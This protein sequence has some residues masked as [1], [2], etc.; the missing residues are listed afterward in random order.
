MISVILYGRN[1]AHGYNL[2]RRAALSLNCIAEV[3]TDPDDEIVFVDYNTPDELP[4][5]IEAI[6]DTLTERCLRL[7]RVVRV[8]A[9]IHEQGFAD[10]TPL[11]VVEP[12]ARNVAA[13]R[14]NPANRWLLSTNTD[15]IFVPLADRSLSE[16]CSDLSDGF[17]GLPR[18]E[19][20]EWLWERLP[21]N[22]PR[23]ALAEVQRLGP[24]LRL[25]E[26]T[27]SH[28]WIRFDAPGDFQLIL[29]DDFVAIHGFDENMRRGYHVDSNV[30]RRLLMH[31]GSIE[32]I[33][34]YLAGYHCNHNRTRTVYHGS[35]VENDI[36]TFFFAIDEPALHAQRS[37]WGL[38]EVSLEEAPIGQLVSTHS[39][40]MLTNVMSS[41]PR[42]PSNAS[43]APVSLAYD[44]GHVLPFIADTLIVSPPHMAVG[45]LGSNVSLERML[46]AFVESHGGDRPLQAAQFHDLPTVDALGRTADILVIDLGIDV[47]QVEAP[48]HRAGR[49]EID[50]FPAAFE[51]VFAALD[52]LIELERER[53]ERGEHPR[54]IVLVN[55]SADYWDTYVLAQF[56]C[57]YTTTHSRVRRAT[58]KR[59]PDD[60]VGPRTARARARQLALWSARRELD[61][62]DVTLRLGESVELAALDDYSG[63]GEG[64]SYPQELGIWAQGPRSSLRMAV[65]GI[66]GSNATEYV[67]TLLIGL[68]CVAPGELLGVE[69]LV[70]GERVAAEEFGQNHAG[71]PWRVDVTSGTL[72]GRRADLT[73]VIDEPRSPVALGWSGDASRLGVLI[74][75]VTIGPVERSMRLGETVTFSE[76]SGAERFLGTG[77]SMLEPTGVWTVDETARLLVDVV[78]SA[79]G[80]VDVVLDVIAFVTPDHP[81]LDV[82]VW[83]RDERLA[84]AVVR[85]GEADH[86]L[87][88]DVRGAPVNGEG[89]VVLDLRLRDP[90][91]PVD[92]GLSSDPRRLG[93]HVRSLT[94]RA[95]AAGGSADQRNAA[96]PGSPETSRSLDTLRKLR[97]QMMRS[98]P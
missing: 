11:P 82:E 55:S 25:D 47:S 64:W 18:F 62:S 71:V 49:G 6:S 75:T 43:E 78:G 26:P 97:R 35:K 73:L 46:G 45:Y 12:V 52:R 32:T 56:D 69:L 54:R 87:S 48:V 72:A 15:M 88:I 77:W 14:A 4:T 90:A 36:V 86:S 29:R 7:L 44:S 83:A 94:V 5:F 85:Y 34:R 31:R 79:Q 23:R 30:S 22:D 61:A 27:L 41:G 96:S 74:R 16:I 67:L 58:V 8:P 51:H 93:L 33:D 28:E 42:T 3:L 50:R 91:R 98:R 40:E 84:A 76:G 1:D 66:D 10:D 39:A 21:R 24:R 89:R 65:D 38:A 19:L 81:R 53:F 60:E 17:Y 63:F 68:V 37:T 59:V 57:S 9:A 13:R 20:P 92:L 80:K 2:H 95:A 70:N